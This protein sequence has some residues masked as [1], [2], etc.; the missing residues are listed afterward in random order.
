MNV[1]SRNGD[2]PRVGDA[3]SCWTFYCKPDQRPLLGVTLAFV[4]G[5]IG[6]WFIT[7]YVWLILEMYG[8]PNTICIGGVHIHHLYTGIVI[9]AV[10]APLVYHYRDRAVPLL[11]SMLALGA[12]AGLIVSD[13]V[14]HFVA[15][16]E[17][18]SL[19]C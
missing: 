17:V 4:I 15:V 7:D 10:A 12:G 5:F 2:S 6:A 14:G 19:L 18:F 8:I 16:T 1:K 9:A 3:S 11:I 13:I